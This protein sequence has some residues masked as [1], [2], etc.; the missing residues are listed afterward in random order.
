[1]GH[2]DTT[3][4]FFNGSMAGR[5]AR[6]PMAVLA[7]EG[8]LLVGYGGCGRPGLGLGCA[9]SLSGVPRLYDHPRFL[10]DVKT[11]ILFQKLSHKSSTDH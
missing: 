2:W 8:G 11:I 1:M 3:K 10:E 6:I 5:E 9:E 4:C 7:S